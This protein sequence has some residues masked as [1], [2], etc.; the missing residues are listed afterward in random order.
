M[1]KPTTMYAPLA[2]RLYQLYECPEEL[3]DFEQWVYA[4]ADELEV[5]L[6]EDLFVLLL[7]FPYQSKYAHHELFSALGPHMD[8]GA[9][10]RWSLEKQLEHI[11]E[12]DVLLLDALV[13][14]YHLSRNGYTFLSELGMSFGL[15]V[16]AR[17]DCDLRVLPK[18]EGKAAR[19]QF[20]Q[21]QGP[22]A[23]AE[24]RQ[25]M[26]WLE[27]GQIVLTGR[28]LGRLREREFIDRRLKH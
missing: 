6:P 19:E 20:R 23:V 7:S 10:E 2:V 27:T 11:I 3:R 9:Y 15:D 13:K 21:E 14:M 17:Y 16:I 12:L 1:K 24:A 8:W 5:Q 4:E 22:P 26:Q 28:R 18:A 25:V